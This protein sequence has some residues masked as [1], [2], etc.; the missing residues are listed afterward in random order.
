MNKTKDYSISTKQILDDLHYHQAQQIAQQLWHQGLI[1][2]EQL[3]KLEGLNA[4]S[5]PPLLP[6]N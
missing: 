4:Q 1:S 2:T 5:F 6:L 3:H